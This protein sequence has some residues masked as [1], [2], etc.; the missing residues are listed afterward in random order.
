MIFCFYIYA[1]SNNI[2]IYNL[3]LY[4]RFQ[5]NII[6]NDDNKRIN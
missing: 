2:Y 5:I 1:N 6:E 3:D 4:V